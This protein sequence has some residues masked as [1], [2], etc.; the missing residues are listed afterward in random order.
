MSQTRTMR[1]AVLAAGTTL[2]VVGCSASGSGDSKSRPAQS[3][4]APSASRPAA[5][6]AGA[7]KAIAAN[8]P[9][10][11]NSAPITAESDPNHLLGRPGQYT[12]KI[13]FSDSRIKAADTEGLEPGDVALGGAVEVFANPA[14]AQARA[15]YIQTVTKGMPALTEYDYVH[16]S[17]LIRVSHYLTPGQAGEYETAA[18]KLP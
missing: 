15:A 13:T 14:D 17:T 7:Y 18:D 4:A 10:A 5:D 9:S 8:V 2:L 6:A 3:S 1:L 11:A 12:S 16:G